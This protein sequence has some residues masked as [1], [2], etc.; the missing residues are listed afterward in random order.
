MQYANVIYVSKH[1]DIWFHSHRYDLT[2]R[3]YALEDNQIAT[4]LCFLDSAEARLVD[5]ECPLP[6]LGD[7]NNRRRI[8]AEI[9][10]P[11]FIV[12]RDRW[13]RSV[14]IENHTEYRERKHCVQYPLDYPE[15][16]SWATWAQTTTTDD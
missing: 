1:E 10:M 16:E 12:F 7:R 11:E 2:D 14:N 4:L 5:S 6:I 13:E 8:D 15:L 9:A 3:I